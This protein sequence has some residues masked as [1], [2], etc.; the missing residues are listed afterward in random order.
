M[1]RIGVLLLLMATP[2]T[3]LARQQRV[4][5]AD[6]DST[7][8]FRTVPTPGGRFDPDHR[9]M[10]SA[11]WRRASDRPRSAS[12][13]LRDEG[14]SFGV[15]EPDDLELVRDR[16]RSR[17]RH[18]TYRQ[19]WAGLPVYGRS[20]GVN[21]DERGRV[22]MVTSS[23]TPIDEPES[24]FDVRPAVSQA[25][26]RRLGLAAVSPAGGRIHESRLVV[27]PE[28]PARLAWELLVFPA[29]RPAEYRV[30]VDARSGE[31]IRA[32]DQAVRSGGRRTAERP[33]EEGRRMGDLP[34]ERELPGDAPAAAVRRVDGSGFAYVPGPLMTSGS[35][36]TPPFVDNADATNPQLDA[37]RVEVVLR[38]I[39]F[40]QDRGGYVLTGPYVDIIDQTYGGTV[41]FEPPVEASPD[42]FRYARNEPGFEAVNAYYHIDL[43]Q[44]YVQ[45]LGIPDR[46]NAPL[47]VNPREKFNDD[48]FY[49]PTQNVL[50]FG[51]G[52][53]DDA[54]DA[55][56]LWHEYA[57][58]LLHAAAP[59]ILT[60]GTLEGRAVHEGWSD[61]WATSWVREL[62][63]EGAVARND[64]QRIFMW[65]SGDGEIWNGRT[66]DH[67]GHYPEDICSDTEPASTCSHHDDGRLLATTLHE[68]RDVIDRRTMDEIVLRS[69]DYLGGAVT[70]AD[71]AAAIVQADIDYFGGVHAD[72]LIGI[73]DARGLVD[74]AEYGPVVAH[75]PLHNTEN[76][77][78]TVDVEAAVQAFSAGVDEVILHVTTESSGSQSFGMSPVSGS[79]YTASIDLPS[80]PDTVRYWIEARD[81]QGF[82]GLLPSGAPGSRFTFGVGPDTTPPEITHEPVEVSSILS[83]P[84]SVEATV[85]DNIG[86]DRVDVAFEIEGPDGGLIDEGSFELDEDAGRFTGSFPTPVEQIRRDAIV[87]Y[88]ITAVDASTGSNESSMPAAG[89]NEFTIGAE[90]LLREFSFESGAGAGVT[91]TGSWE[92]GAPAYGLLTAFRGGS[93]AGTDLDGSTAESAGLSTMRLPTLNLTGIGDARLRFVHWFDTEHDGNAQPGSPGATLF[94]GG[95]VKVSTDGGAHWTVLTPVIG[96]YTG[97]V[98]ASSGN[99]LAGEMAFGGYGFGWRI[100]E[101]E[102][103]EAPNV[104][105]RFDFATDSGNTRETRNHAG[106]FLDDIRVT[107]AGLDDTEPPQAGA[108][109]PLSGVESTQS[110]RPVVQIDFSDATVV[111]DVFLDYRYEY[112]DD[113]GGTDVQTGS[114]RMEMR[115]ESTTLFESVLEFVTAPEPGDVLTYSIRASDAAGN[116]V[117]L[118]G[119]T[120]PAYRIEFRLTEQADML[121]GVAVSGAWTFDGGQWQVSSAAGEPAVSSLN[122]TAVE[123]PTNAVRIRLEIAHS[124]QIVETAAANVKVSTDAGRI[125]QLIEPDAGYDGPAPLPEAHPMGDEAAF[126]GISGGILIDRFDLTGFAGR[127]IL[128]RYDFGSDS[129]AAT[130]DFWRLSTARMLVETTEPDFEVDRQT[131]LHPVF[132]N[133]AY[134]RANVSVTVEDRG[135]V[136]VDVFDLLG[137]RVARLEAGTLE[138]GTHS[139]SFDTDGWAAGVYVVRLDT[140]GRH[141]STTLVVAR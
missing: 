82:V 136:G 124:Y 40:D 1:V 42:D 16:V 17:T 45:S 118:P 43:S 80:V 112:G 9:V 131:V 125:W 18:L 119:G 64:W 20:V 8:R 84:E 60:F 74:R 132:P 65:D 46:Q 55:T 47:R 110:I 59:D 87:R 138:P 37:E 108:E 75:D 135:E 140:A 22:T 6:H 49:L 114:L 73:F 30:L 4:R 26:A 77:G 67:F 68:A 7:L 36:Y 61:Y 107:T 88:R 106:W 137:R 109:P 57:H 44:R 81:D 123:L 134:A 115:P 105:I 92:I 128:V 62:V 27:L 98:D 78:G 38:D 3:A 11:T 117:E 34:A 122:A 32:F 31:V 93:A 66:M 21:L 99:P 85:T 100:A 35:T 141:Y 13:F 79:L 41:D 48:S 130:G 104:S 39:M 54:E 51:L 133:P 127:Q 5:V 52:G 126:G 111:T 121:S 97:S 14:A 33:L 103:P 12:A 129:D 28:E 56:V 71:A 90:G 76:L 69:H 15:R 29:D 50:I 101:F 102:L 58:A 95:N 91:L 70:F 120:G 63:E 116:T 139:F 113:G 19:T 83:W 94:D 25:D 96:S 24:L 86:V 23:F 10:R 89:F 2:L 72:V 53:V